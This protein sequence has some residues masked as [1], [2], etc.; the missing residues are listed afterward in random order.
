MGQ[1]LRW[2][3]DKAFYRS[4]MRLV[5]PVMIQN[6]IT[7]FVNMLD[8][9]MVGQVGTLP[10]S[11]ASVANQIMMVFNLAVFGANGAIG[12]FCAQY[13]GKGDREGVSRCFHLKVYVS[14]LISAAGIL[15][16]LLF[17]DSLLNLYMDPGTN[18]A[19]DIALTMGYA[20]TYMLIMLAGLPA[21]TQMQAIGSTAREGGETV[22]PMIASVTAVL[23][24]FIGNYTLIFGHFG[25]PKMGIAGAALA[26]VLSR[27]VEFLIIFLGTHRNREKFFFYDNFFG[28]IAV[29]G[30]LIREIAVKGAPLV[31]NEILWSFSVA[32][33]AQSYSTRG[34]SAVAA[35]NINQTIMHVF[36]ITNM[37][38]G[39]AIS[40][41]VGQ[42]LGANEIEDAVQ[43]DWQLMVFAFL[44]SAVLGC[45]L[46]LFAP[47]VPE[48]YNTSREVKDL[49]QQ[50]LKITAVYL[51]VGALYHAGYSTM[52]AGGKTVITFL[53]DSVYSC[54]V[55]LPIAFCLSRFTD[56]PVLQIFLIVQ[57]SDIPKAL[58]GVWLVRRRVWVQNLV[59]TEE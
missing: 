44:A 56:L 35:I 51:P 33:I 10:M 49:A 9:I 58:L 43:T 8:N 21:F 13:Y 20:R 34:L 4:V 39:V 54:C 17:G 22:L 37:A 42:K 48:L 23:V 50:L 19:E 27:Y 24:N 5:I 55:N 32:A 1:K 40:V 53:F 11:A 16:L 18:T 29:P 52:R 15:A 28:A 30:K 45:V 31:C 57:A 25:A 6:G 26:T 41:M 12:I 7:T 2:F 47:V 3:G 59:G 36:M 38:Q 14:L 46:F